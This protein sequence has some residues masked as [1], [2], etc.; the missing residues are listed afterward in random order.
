MEIFAWQRFVRVFLNDLMLL[1]VKRIGFASLGLLGVGIVIYVTNAAATPGDNMD[2]ALTT[3]TVLL[4]GG[5]HIFTSMIFNDMHHPLERFHYLMLPCSNLERFVSRY[6]ITAPLFFVYA[7]VFF[8]VFEVV[9]NL[10]ITTLT[11]AQPI[12]P[13]QLGSD[14]ARMSM[15]AYFVTHVFVYCGAIW[16]RS[17]ALVKTM[18]TGMILWTGCLLLFFVALRIL[19]WDSFISLFQMNPEG[20]FP[21]IEADF[22]TDADGNPNVPAKLALTLFLGWVLFLAYL[23]LEEHEV[24]DG[25]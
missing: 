23:G 6:L 10:V 13:L 19:Y 17:Y 14:A 16:F 21:G 15:L 12:P 11:D 3:F 4:L 20:P 24:Q 2:V 9:A 8:K 25:L 1:Q 18:A 22:L 7:V 5:G